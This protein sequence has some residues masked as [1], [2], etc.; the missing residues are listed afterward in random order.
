MLWSVLLTLIFFSVIVFVHEFGHF[1]V[2]RLFKISVNEFAI[3]MGPKI[4]SKEKNGTV[5]SLRA[6]PLGGFCSLEGED[7]V[8]E[9][10]EGAFSQKPWYARLL[11]LVAGA[12]MNLVL[13]FLI[14]V[15]FVSVFYSSSGIPTTTV[16]SVMEKSS[17]YDVLKPGD[18]IVR[19]NEYNIKIK[20]DLDFAMQQSG[21]GECEIEVVR[22]GESFVRAFKPIEAQY[23]DGTPAYLVGIVPKIQS[24]NI[25]TVLRESFYQTVWMGKLVFVS[26]KML[27]GGQAKITEVSGPVGVVEAMNTQAQTGGFVALLYLAGFLSVNIGIMNLLPIPALDGGRILFVIIEAIRRKPIPPEKE[28]LVHF[29]GLVLLLGFMV[30]VTWN[31]IV[32]LVSAYF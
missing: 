2:A 20:K 32:R 7:S 3:G 6:I 29:A 26:L 27:L 1:F 17:L 30:F 9:D 18:R 22:G 31:D 12:A 5:Y 21:G 16:D 11:V 8:S 24:V 4:F 23:T 15:V 19:L 28:G 13:G 25:G 10:T 14:S